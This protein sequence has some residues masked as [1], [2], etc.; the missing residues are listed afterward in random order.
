MTVT[1]S[2]VTGPLFADVY[3]P[4]GTP[5]PTVAYA[6][7]STVKVS[8]DYI[9]SPIYGCQQPLTFIALRL[10]IYCAMTSGQ[11]GIVMN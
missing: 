7:P 10:G 11:V 3:Y 5:S 8:E 9:P 6:T 1:F 2:N 4:I